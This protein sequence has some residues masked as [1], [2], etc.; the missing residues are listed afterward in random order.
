MDS[1]TTPLT[2]TQIAGRLGNEVATGE[3]IGGM[4]EPL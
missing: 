2:F 4:L 3:A 1:P